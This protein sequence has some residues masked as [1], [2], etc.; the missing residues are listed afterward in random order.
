MAMIRME[1]IRGMDAIPT[2]NLK[3]GYQVVR[4]KD[5][6]ERM[7]EKNKTEGMK[8]FCLEDEST[9]EL[10]KNKDGKLVFQ[11]EDASEKEIRALFGDDKVR[12]H[13]ND[14]SDQK[15]IADAVE[16]ENVLNRPAFFPPVSHDHDDRY[17]KR[18][19]ALAVK[20]AYDIAVDNGFKGTEKEWIESLKGKDGTTP[21]IKIG[22][23]K[24]GSPA[25]VVNSG[26]LTDAVLDF[27]LPFEKLERKIVDITI[28]PEDWKDGV[29]AVSDENIKEDSIVFVRAPQSATAD[30]F[31]AV[32]AAGIQYKYGGAGKGELYALT[33]VPKASVNLQLIII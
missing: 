23:V 32:M 31:K 29:F 14:S 27:T 19:E 10:V 26:T 20:S 21:S 7:P 8:V 1:Q 4:T 11:Q 33:A 5:F 2:T 22:A 13:S 25:N 30:E 9:Y 12:P 6:L 18:S 16:W 28:K 15:F 3:G 17:I 24:E